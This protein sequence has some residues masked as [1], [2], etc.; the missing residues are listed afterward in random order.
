M[1]TLEEIR[2]KLRGGES[3]TEIPPAKAGA[4]DHERIKNKRGKNSKRYTVA[5]TGLDATL[6]FGKNEGSSISDLAKTL[7]GRGYLDYILKEFQDDELKEIVRHQRNVAGF[8]V[9]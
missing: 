3:P 9:R 6:H 5:I 7:S 8:P 1:P 2:A 4:L